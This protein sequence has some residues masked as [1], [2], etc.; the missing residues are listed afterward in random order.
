[1]VA[2]WLQSKAASEWLDENEAGREL[3][4]VFEPDVVEVVY[5]VVWRLADESRNSRVIRYL[6]HA[7]GS[8]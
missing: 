6:S 8:D 1:M 4:G 3:P 5:K 7:A 2:I